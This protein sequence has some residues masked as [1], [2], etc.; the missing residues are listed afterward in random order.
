[1]THKVY[2]GIPLH[3]CQSCGWRWNSFEVRKCPKC[4]HILEQV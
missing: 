4:G 3:V 2:N 1:M